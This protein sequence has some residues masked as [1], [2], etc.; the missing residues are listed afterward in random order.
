MSWSLPEAGFPRGM[1]LAPSFRRKVPCW[2]FALISLETKPA[3]SISL[4]WYW[5]ACIHRRIVTVFFGIIDGWSQPSVS[6][7]T[8]WE[9]VTTRWFRPFTQDF[10]H[11]NEHERYDM[12]ASCCDTTLNPA[13]SLCI[14]RWAQMLVQYLSSYIMISL[15]LEEEP[16]ETRPREREDF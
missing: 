10:F 11:Q 13:S 16:L 2:L 1:W 4:Y 9:T 5:R 15:S 3:S 7:L 6:P 8:E 14:L 12:D